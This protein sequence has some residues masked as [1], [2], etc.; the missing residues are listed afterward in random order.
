MP[1]LFNKMALKLSCRL[2]IG[3]A[4]TALLLA[5]ACS[6][7]GTFTPQ[8]SVAHTQATTA[9]SAVTLP[10]SA[11]DS[12]PAKLSALNAVG[13]Q[14]YSVLETIL[15]VLGPRESGTSQESAAANYLLHQLQD[16]GYATEIQE[17]P[18]ENIALAGLGLTVVSPEYV[19]FEAIPL[20]ETGL[21]NVTGILTSVGLAMLGDIPVGGL[22]GHIALAKRGV[23]P[24]ETKAQ[25]VF[26]AG[27]VGLV[28]YNSLPG[29]FKGVLVT[30]PDFPVIS[31]SKYDGAVVESMCVESE[32]R[33]SI[34]LSIGDN[35]SRNVIA[36]K[37]GTSD[38]VVVLGGHYDSVAGISGANDNASGTAVLLTIAKILADVDLP[39]TLR[40]VPFGAEELGLL[41]SRHYVDS[42][43]EVESD[44]TKVML[45]FDAVGTGSGV[46]V[47]GS[48]QLV[49]LASSTA[50]K[51]GLDITVTRGQSGGSS[52]Y[53]NFQRV[54]IP[55]LMFFG[56]DQSRIH[57]KLD[58][59]EFVS[60][61]MLGGAVETSVA[62]LQSPEFADF[63]ISEAN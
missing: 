47:F 9:S 31:I 8:P 53:A 41:G 3:F 18:V 21:G 32:V 14:A 30:Q 36:E 10:H 34:N 15:E 56:D 49:E 40:I 5:V 55:F 7:T 63:V 59:I 4:I 35:Q 48:P 52:D 26:D 11:K 25:N 12:D 27:A 57:S 42:L 51:N 61:E 62:L 38:A 20:S 44:Q 37:Q 16:L 43:T 13:T 46:S 1:R 19:E 2:R 33:V 22:E 17:F 24:F 60:S 28:I 54:E 29:N 50:E 23:I 58:T 6:G 45:N 39:F